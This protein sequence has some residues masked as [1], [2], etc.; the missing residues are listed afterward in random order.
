MA[1]GV[2]QRC[3]MDLIVIDFTAVQIQLCGSGVKESLGDP[4]GEKRLS[5]SPLLFS[6]SLKC[7]CFSADPEA[8]QEVCTLAPKSSHSPLVCSH[9]RGRLGVSTTT[10]KKLQTKLTLQSNKWALDENEN[11]AF[12]LFTNDGL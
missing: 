4:L 3:E 1:E 12:L 9:H 8:A 7:R 5:K 11:V 2:F 10:L 6:H